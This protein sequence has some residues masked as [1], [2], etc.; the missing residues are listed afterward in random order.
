[1]GIAGGGVCALA[2]AWQQKGVLRAGLVKARE[3]DAHTFLAALLGDDDWVGEP[4]G[5]AHLMD[6]SSFLWLVHFLNNELLLLG[7]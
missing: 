5:M 3:V 7:H 4:F 1:V 2:D 6:D